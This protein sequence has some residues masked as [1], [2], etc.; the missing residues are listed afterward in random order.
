MG[1]VEL[2]TQL[3]ALGA[4]HGIG[5]V[6]MVE[7]RLV[8][9]KSRGVY[10]TPG[11]TILYETHRMLEQLVLDRD[12]ALLKQR[13]AIE[14][15]QMVYDGRWFCP[16]KQALDAFVQSTQKNMTGTVKVKLYKGNIVPAGV[17]SKQSLYHHD[18]A[19]FS[20]TDLYNQQDAT[21]FI[22]LFGLPMKVNGMV[23]RS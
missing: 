11:G 19:S 14:Y 15:A 12:T 2:L 7:N 23:G 16:A 20:D 9:M 18:L 21:G 8:G 22:R 13:L 6:D 4:A 5:Q 17:A 1:P 10:E 3:N